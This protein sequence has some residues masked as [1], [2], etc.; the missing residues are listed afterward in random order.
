MIISLN[1][2]CCKGYSSHLVI[3]F[4]QMH[5]P[6]LQPFCTVSL[7]PVWRFFGSHSVQTQSSSVLREAEGKVNLSQQSSSQADADLAPVRPPQQW[8]CSVYQTSSSP[9]FSRLLCSALVLAST[10]SYNSPTLRCKA[11]YFRPLAEPQSMLRPLICGD[12]WLLRYLPP[13]FTADLSSTHPSI[14]PLPPGP[15][16]RHR[17]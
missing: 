15:S 7:H 10:L 17:A 3:C 13:S 5:P 12:T 16:L 1:T 8:R 9:L 4:L 11:A 6:I 14:L 2:N